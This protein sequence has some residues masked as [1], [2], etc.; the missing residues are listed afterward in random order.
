MGSLDRA[1]FYAI[2]GWPESMRPFWV[3]ISEATKTGWVRIALGILVL[4]LIIAGQK[5]RKATL[6]ALAAWPLANGLTEAFKTAIAFNRPCVDLA[7]TILRVPMLTSYG[8]ASSH[9]ANMGAI[10]FVY[11]YVTGKWGI[12]WLIIA[13]LTGIS[14][15]YVGAHYPSQVLFGWTC[16]AFCGFLVVKTWEA[17]AN[18]RRRSNPDHEPQPASA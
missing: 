6:L 13:I 5:S 17:F 9:S 14:R 11:L 8:T 4:G 7:D 12:P 2:N 3:G 18:R 1:I 15:I 16:G 10:A